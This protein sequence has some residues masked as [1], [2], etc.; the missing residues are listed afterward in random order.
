VVGTLE[1]VSRAEQVLTERQ[2]EIISVLGNQI[3]I[4]I[5]NTTLLT[6]TTRKAREALTLYRVSAEVSAS[7]D[8]DQVLQ[9]VATGARDALAGDVCVVCLFDAAHQEI[10][11]RAI[12]GG[13]YDNWLGMKTP[14][15][16][17][18]LHKLTKPLS[19]TDHSPNLNTHLVEFL[20]AEKLNSWVVAPLLRGEL[21]LGIVVVLVRGYR[22]FIDE[23]MRLLA[24]LAQ[25]VA[26]AIENARLYQKVHHMAV[27]EERDRLAREMHDELAQTL[28]YLNLQAS[29]TSDLVSSGESVQAQACLL[30]MKQITRQIYTDTREAIFH[31]RNSVSS[32]A[33]LLPMLKEYLAEY[34]AHYGLDARLAAADGLQIN[35]PTDIALQL[36]R[37]IQEGLTNI[38]KHAQAKH[39]WVSFER[40]QAFIRIVIEDDGRGF[41]HATMEVEGAEHYGLQI[42]RE[43]A[44][45]VGVTVELDSG[46]GSGTR[47]IIRV[48]AHV[49]LED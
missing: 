40:E 18:H 23:E 8:L 30:E 27:L 13:S 17:I 34:S 33:D 22:V 42:M 28:G 39:A 32:G 10:V 2:I 4:A 15:E 12:A 48:P 37:I 9:A 46:I 3:G 35:F 16:G 47:V 41:D 21:F 14:V 31:L 11:V 44:E 24:S 20:K 29:I 49:C 26:C 38:R 43:R 7:L 25:Q 5:E 45:S 6:E 36:S 19:Q 1:L